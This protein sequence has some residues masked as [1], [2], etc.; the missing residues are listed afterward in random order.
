MIFNLVIN[1]YVITSIENLHFIL[2]FF[3]YL[4]MDRVVHGR[5]QVRRKKPTFI[6]WSDS[7]I[8]DRQ[9]ADLSSEK[10]FHGKIALALR[11]KDSDDESSYEVQ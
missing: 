9:I 7:L 10:F 4:Y 5:R 8:L 11:Y 2:N 3:Q 6:G 1:N